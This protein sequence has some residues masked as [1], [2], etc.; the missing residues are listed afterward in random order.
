MYRLVYMN[1]IIC[2]KTIGL[3]FVLHK[4]IHDLNRHAK[5]CL[6]SKD[7]FPELVN[8]ISKSSCDYFS[9]QRRL[10]TPFFGYMT[11]RR[12]SEASRRIK[13]K[14]LCSFG[15]PETDYT[16]TRRHIPEE[17]IES[18]RRESLKQTFFCVPLTSTKFQPEGTFKYRLNFYVPLINI[19]LF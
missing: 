13:T 9:R 3:V 10:R 12:W 4:L 5:S 6:T 7:I 15:T 11:P 14:A 17:Y 1:C 2:L 8:N 16:V 18:C 19:T